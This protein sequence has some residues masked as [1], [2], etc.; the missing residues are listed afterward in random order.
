MEVYMSSLP[1]HPCLD[2]YRRQAKDLLHAAKAGDPSVLELFRATH[3]K[4][5]DKPQ[6]KL[7]D[8]QYVVARREGY[9]SWPKFRD[10]VVTAE[11]KDFFDEVENADVEAVQRRLA[12]M[13]KLVNATRE[14]GESALHVAA[15][16]NDVALAEVLVKAGADTK[17][18]FGY[19]AHTALSWAITV[20]SFEFAQELVRLGDEPDLFSAA[21]L[22]D[23]GRVQAFW[24]EG[25]M[26]SHPSTTG[27]SRFAADGTRLPRPPETELEVISDAMVIAC[28]NG[29]PDVALWLLSKG[30]DLTFRGYIGGTA[31]HWAEYSGN[32]E[33]CAKL[34]A[35]GAS[36]E[37]EDAEFLAHPVAFGLLVT[38][39]WGIVPRLSRLLDIHPENVNIRGGYG[40]A[41]N[42]AAW[43]NQ[44]ECAKLLLSRGADA[45]LKNAA[46]LTPLEVAYHKGFPELV[47]LFE[48]I[49]KK[50]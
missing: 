1:E 13:P 10:A 15:G 43:N 42:A 44:L 27:S 14:G 7:T 22:G 12:R 31:L 41:L 29:H 48:S 38:A 33:L 19:S 25:K 39:A 18:L 20:G 34:R 3:P 45:T 5:L 24:R 16:H 50:D 23:L 6:L 30:A 17:R 26:R 9:A 8:A 46:G 37:L 4:C 32:Q 47:V 21:G 11:T 35:A 2:Q 28:R 49:A 40:T 36:D